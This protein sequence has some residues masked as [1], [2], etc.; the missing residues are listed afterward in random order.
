MSMIHRLLCRMGLHHWHPGY[1][2]QGERCQSCNRCGK[3]RY[4]KGLGRIPPPDSFTMDHV[5]GIGPVG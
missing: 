1:T 4:D 2:Q 5:G 3:E